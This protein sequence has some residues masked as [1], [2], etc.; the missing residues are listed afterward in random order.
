MINLR[1]FW[2]ENFADC[3][4][5]SYL[6]KYN[7]TDRWFRFHSLPQSKRYAENEPEYSELLERQN[8]A[9]LDVIGDDAD[10]LLIT[11]NYAD[12]PLEESFT[13]CPALSDFEF[14]DFIRISKQNFNPEELETDEEPAYLNL[15]FTSHKLKR[16]SLDE[17]L[18]CIADVKL[19]NTFILNCETKRIFAPYDGG[20]DVI[21]KNSGERNEFRLKYID[22]L[23]AHPQAL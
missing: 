18:L 4:P 20:V 1:K 3:P 14:Q 16:G 22:W 10:C 15:F 12:S 17:I 6:F 23:S 21:L 5:V 2:Q 9:L 8:T 11:G 13:N 19:I 7:L